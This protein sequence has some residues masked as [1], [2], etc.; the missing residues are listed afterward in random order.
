MG[1]NAL[2]SGKWRVTLRQRTLPAA[3][4]Q[5]R[6]TFQTLKIPLLGLQSAKTLH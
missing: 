6:D 1:R 5:A 2:I 3:Y 4:L